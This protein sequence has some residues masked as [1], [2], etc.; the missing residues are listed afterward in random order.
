MPAENIINIIQK[1]SSRRGIK[2]NKVLVFI[3]ALILSFNSLPCFA[4]E[5]VELETITETEMEFIEEPEFVEESPFEVEN[6]KEEIELEESNE[7]PL[8]LDQPSFTG[9]VTIKQKNAGQIFFGDRITLKAIVKDANMDFNL[10][11]EVNRQDRNGWC[12]LNGET[13][14]EYNFIITKENQNYE[15]RVIL[16]Y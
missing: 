13:N 16:I 5:I 2:L 1:I 15:Y 3:V 12:I 6:L 14:Q 7:T 8:G 10:R 4:E 11:W 9:T